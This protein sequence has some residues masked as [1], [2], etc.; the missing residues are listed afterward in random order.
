[1]QWWKYGYIMNRLIII[2]SICLVSSLGT[3]I[4]AEDTVDFFRDIK[5]IMVAKCFKCHSQLEAESELRLDSIAAMLTGGVR[6]PA[7]VKGNSKASLLI[8]VLQDEEEDLLMPAGGP[9]LKS[10][11]IDLIAKWLSLIHI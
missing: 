7:I 11:Q 2:S 8:R 6:G 3:M 5:P 9:P 10:Q 1:M 4:H